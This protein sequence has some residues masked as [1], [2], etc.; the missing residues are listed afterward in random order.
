MDENQ[1]ELA[2]FAGRCFWCM[3]SPFDEMPGINRVV[4]GYT[5]GHTENPSCEQVCSQETGHYE[6]VQI[7]LN[8]KKNIL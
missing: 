3:V 6:A 2:T 1:N 4:S 5:G 8:P 7:N